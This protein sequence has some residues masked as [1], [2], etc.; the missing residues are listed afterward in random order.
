MLP[1]AM[2]SRQA[3]LD[4]HPSINASMDDFEERQF[5]PTV[6]EMP[7]QHSGFRSNNNSEYSESSRRSYSPP[8]WRKSGSGWFKHQSLSPSR[9]GYGSKE[10]SPQYHSADEDGEV[11]T[12]RSATRIPLPASPTKGR[13]PAHSPEPLNG[14][15]ADDEDAGGGDATLTNDQFEMEHTT[16]RQKSPSENCKPWPSGFCSLKSAY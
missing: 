3:F 2:T 10:P 6:P 8:A 13:T 9:S 5:S 4:S 1:T 16:P 14:V 11:T 7:S 12:Y 15:G